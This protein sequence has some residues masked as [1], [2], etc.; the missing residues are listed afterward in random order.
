MT[1]Q[2]EHLKLTLQLTAIQD[3]LLVRANSTR[4]ESKAETD[5]PS[6][7]LLA[8]LARQTGP[9]IPTPQLKS[10]GQT[11]HRL[12]LAGAV[13]QLAADMLAEAGQT[14]RPLHLELRFD[15][16]QVALAQFPWEI[17]TGPTGQFL[18][19]DGVVDLTRYIN[20][21][22]PPP[23]F[24]AS[25]E[26]LPLVQVVSQP[27]QLPAVAWEAV[28][29]ENVEILTPPSFEQ[30]MF[31]LLIERLAS[32]GLQFNGAGAL[33]IQ[34]PMCEGLNPLHAA[35]CRQCQT[36]LSP[37]RPIGALAFE[38]DGQVD[39]VPTREVGDILYNAGVQLALLLSSET[40]VVDD[41]VVFNGLASS[42]IL[43]GVPA[44]L[45]MQYPVSSGFAGRFLNS[46]YLTLLKEHDVLA[47]L[48][49]ARRINMRGAW[50]SPALYMRHQKAVAAGEPQTAAYHTRT[51][52]TAVPAEALVRLPFLVRLWIRR[53]ETQPLSEAQLRV[54]LDVP[55]HVSIRTGESDVDLKFE[56]VVGRKLRRG[57]VS[58]KLKAPECELTPESIKLFVDEDVDAPAAIFTVTPRRPGNSALVFQVEQDGGQVATITHTIH[59]LDTGPADIG[60]VQAWSYAMPLGDMPEV[61]TSTNE[62]H[63]KQ[64]LSNYQR[65]LLKL[66][67]KEALLDV[68]T[69]PYILIQ[70]EDLEAKI[71]EVY[72]Q[73]DRLQ[74]SRPAM[75]PEPVPDREPAGSDTPAE[76]HSPQPAPLP[77]PPVP[78][79]VLTP[80]KPAET[81]SIPDPSSSSSDPDQPPA[82]PGPNIHLE[83]ATLAELQ[84]EQINLGL[85]ISRCRARLDEINARLNPPPDSTAAGLPRDE[86]LKLLREKGDLSKQIEQLNE[87]L[88]P[89]V[90]KLNVG[91]P[92]IDQAL[93]EAPLA[94]APRMETPPAPAAAGNRWVLLIGF[95]I[96]GL[97]LLCAL[98]WFLWN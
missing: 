71:T 64:L 45:G 67:E 21:P 28:K 22:Q 77:P 51:I 57:E 34:C 98:L 32:W 9:T 54:E 91:P 97:V 61:I 59:V 18:V 72:E 25:L 47:A 38:G 80:S 95:F 42:L 33:M 86:F 79:D 40:A 78:S 48:R 41:R 39:W 92:P 88:E 76:V 31:R 84:A 19:R 14:R 60:L 1:S 36:K 7:E 53:P 23:A 26:G 70:I 85:Q 4:G 24:D 68:H 81:K 46:F 2:T 13:E 58:V 8:Q 6:P 49:M 5:M 73:L 20:Y 87:Q 52:D 96:I 43:A 63:L 94:P 12:L 3:R 82:Q 29:L 44:A 69:P 16:D 15:A 62:D 35:T 11:L 17:I 89:A 65:Y 75:Q 50:Y 93:P 74:N 10:D 56:P 90:D 37:E 83:K 66:K 55:E 30:L 27:P